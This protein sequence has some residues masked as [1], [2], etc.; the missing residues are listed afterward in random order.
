VLLSVA[1]GIQ[2]SGCAVM[3]EIPREQFAAEPVRRHLR[4]TA[5]DGSSWSFAEGRFEA[6]TLVGFPRGG[7]R[8]GEEALQPVRVPLDHVTRLEARR[9][10]WYRTGLLAAT[11][12]AG[13]VVW[14]LSQRNDN[15]TPPPQG[16]IKPF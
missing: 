15:Q 10:D 6:D 2:A 1:L 14:I 3:R 11:A 7:R 8:V 12:I 4:V 13:G 5:E 16:P 9:L